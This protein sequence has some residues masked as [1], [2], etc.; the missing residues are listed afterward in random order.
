M[1]LR[2]YLATE[3]ALDHVDGLLTRREALQR[4]GLLGL[5]AVAASGLLSACADATPAPAAPS[6][7]P[8]ATPD[9]DVAA[10]TARTEAITF[11]GGTGSMSGAFAAAQS[12]KGAVLVV[13]ENRGLTDHIRAVTGRLAGDGYTALAPDLLSRAGGTA[14]APDATAALGAISEADLVADLRSGLA[15]LGRRAS[16]AT[17]GAVGFCF[18]GGMVWQLLNSGPTEL[19]AAAPFYGP[20]P[21]NPAFTGTK[22]A[23]LGIFA[24][25]DDRVNAGRDTLDRALTAAGVTHEFVTEPGAGHAFFN[26]SRS[27]VYRPAAAADAWPRALAF[28]RRYLRV[29]G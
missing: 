6:P 23:V 8:A 1:A 18:G 11:P 28:L 7:A 25:Q 15:E 24:E 5:T 26:D 10:A 16:G 13:H 9:Y 14:G 17:L 19:A 2:S 3:I 12:P 22:A 4:L 29:R 20:A 27:D 21:D